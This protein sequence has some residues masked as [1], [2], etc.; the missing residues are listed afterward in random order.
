MIIVPKHKACLF[1]SDETDIHWCPDTGRTYQ[2]PGQQLKA[3][4]PGKYTVRYLLGSVEY[5]SGEVWS[6]LREKGSMNYIPTNALKTGMLA[7]LQTF[8]GGYED[9]YP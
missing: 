1:F 5:P 9:S 6:I 8:G 4:S 2:L 7:G 3:D